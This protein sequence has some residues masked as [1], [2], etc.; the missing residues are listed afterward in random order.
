MGT[1]TMEIARTK[2]ITKSRLGDEYLTHPL[3]IANLTFAFIGKLFIA[4]SFAITWIW[5]LELFPTPI[6]GS[7]LG[8]A[9]L[10]ARIGGILT[11]FL[12]GLQELVPW[13]PGAVFGVM[14]LLAGVLC[15]NL[16]ETRGEEML[17]TIE[18]ALV[19]YGSK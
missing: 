2:C 4:G 7:A 18:D 11:P 19:L 13:L 9:G 17:M 15:T 6:R 1:L 14:S 3:I 16:P 12:L 10:G 5:T 8:F